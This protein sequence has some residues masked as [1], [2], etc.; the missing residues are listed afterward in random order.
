MESTA[1]LIG[2]LTLLVSVVGVYIAV[3]SSNESKDLQVLLE[4]SLDYRN[5]WDKDWHG[6]INRIKQDDSDLRPEDEVCLRSMLNWID[7]Y[8]NI[9]KSGLF[10]RSD[11]FNSAIGPSMSAGVLLAKDLLEKDEAK[12]GSGYWAGLR[13]AESKF[14]DPKRGG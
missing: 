13:F 9:L 7:W 3:K 12:F 5:R 6:V 4:M 2:L 14:V 11:V 8:G 1:I 10:H